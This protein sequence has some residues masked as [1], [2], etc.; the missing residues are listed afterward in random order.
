MI[1]CIS[2]DLKISVSRASALLQLLYSTYKLL[3][4]TSDNLCRRIIFVNMSILEQSNITK[5]VAGQ[6]AHNAFKLILISYIHR[7]SR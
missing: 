2:F 5:L 4:R 6:K 1:G 3:T 7:R